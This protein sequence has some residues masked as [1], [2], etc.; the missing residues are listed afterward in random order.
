MRLLMS[1]GIQERASDSLEGNP[2]EV[3]SKLVEFLRSER[4]LPEEEDTQ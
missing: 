1:G 2:K 4:L 3:A